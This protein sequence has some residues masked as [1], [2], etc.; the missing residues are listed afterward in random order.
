MAL[1]RNRHARTSWSPKKLR[2]CQPLSDVASD[3]GRATSDVSDKES[4]RKELLDSFLTIADTSDAALPASDGTS[5]AVY[6]KR[7][8]KESTL[9]RAKIHL[10]MSPQRASNPPVRKKLR[11][12]DPRLNVERELGTLREIAARN[13]DFSP[14]RTLD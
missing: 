3:A 2:L 13:L 4:K 9:S 14:A 5:D 10:C 7:I 12:P 11:P 1:C 6:Q 8:K